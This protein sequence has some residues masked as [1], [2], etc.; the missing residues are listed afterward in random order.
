MSDKSWLQPIHRASLG[1]DGIPECGDFKRGACFRATCKFLHG[2]K[3]AAE[4]NASGIP[5]SVNGGSAGLPTPRPAGAFIAPDDLDETLYDS[6]TGFGLFGTSVFGTRYGLNG[7]L[8]KIDNV[9]PLCM[10]FYK[11]GFCNRRGPHNQGCLFRHD[12][13]EGKGKIETGK[14]EVS[15][16]VEYFAMEAQGKM[17]KA[18]RTLAYSD[19]SK[20]AAEWAAKRREELVLEDKVAADTAAA[21]ERVTAAAAHAAPPAAMPTPPAAMP[22]PPKPV[23][24]GGPAAGAEPPLP[25]GWKQAKAGDG[26]VYYFHT[27]TK[28]TQWTRPVPT[29]EDAAAAVQPLPPGWKEAKAADG[30]TYYFQAGT[31]VTQ[32]VRPTAQQANPPLTEQGASAGGDGDPA[33]KRSRHE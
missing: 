23:V 25:P 3:P 15:W 31:N 12:E 22:T 10:D 14:V 21:V 13:I 24:N 27:A 30:R 1:D 20:A 8:P 32:W 11:Q 28:K 5:G 29:P 7:P 2:G 33:A 9:R 6:N 17:N 4:A 26:R 19:I 16:E 18:G